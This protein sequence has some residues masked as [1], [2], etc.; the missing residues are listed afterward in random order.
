MILEN[1][2]IISRIPVKKAIGFPREINFFR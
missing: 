1:S 2:E